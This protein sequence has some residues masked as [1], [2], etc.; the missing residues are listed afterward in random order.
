ME[1]TKITIRRDL[2]GSLVKGGLATLPDSG[3]YKISNPAH[4]PPHGEMILILSTSL[5]WPKS[6]SKSYSH[7]N[8]DADSKVCKDDLLE[9]FQ[10]RIAERTAE[11]IKNQMNATELVPKL[12]SIEPEGLVLVEA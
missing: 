5:L 3:T 6:K 8:E 10:K 1:T 7:G 2:L 12:L 9:I 11:R 4:Y